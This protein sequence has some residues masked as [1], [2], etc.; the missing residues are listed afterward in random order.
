MTAGDV[1]VELLRGREITRVLGALQARG[2]ESIL[3]K[4]T[5]LAYSVYVA[6][7]LRPRED[8]DLLIRA[9]DAEAVRRVMKNLGYTAPAYDDAVH[10]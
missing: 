5:A 10:Y 7:A 9:G 3:L 1:A 6:P 8:T 4:G 2:I